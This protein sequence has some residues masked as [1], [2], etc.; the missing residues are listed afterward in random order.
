MPLGCS[1]PPGRNDLKGCHLLGE[2][3]NLIQERLPRKSCTLRFCVDSGDRSRQCP[4]AGRETTTPVL[5]A[6]RPSD[7]IVRMVA[8]NAVMTAGATIV[9]DEARRTTRF[10]ATRG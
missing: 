7:R 6:A 3:P 4:L 5:A 2:S 8:A 1:A 10:V 9:A